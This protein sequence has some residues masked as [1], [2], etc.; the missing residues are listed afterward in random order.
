MGLTTM[1]IDYLTNYLIGI[2][3]LATLVSSIVVAVRKPR[4]RVAS[5]TIAA[6]LGSLIVLPVVVFMFWMVTLG[7]AHV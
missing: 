5:I 4:Y 3:V 6:A 2:A 1:P 7:L